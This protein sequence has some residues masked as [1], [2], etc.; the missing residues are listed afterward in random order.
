M[1]RRAFLKALTAGPLFTETLSHAVTEDIPGPGPLGDTL[2]VR[3]DAPDGPL[4]SRAFEIL[5]SRVGKRCPIR[6]VRADTDA[7]LI[8]A[9]SA[10][11]PQEG[12][13][14]ENAEGV[15][16][17][18]GGSPSG[19]IYGVGKFLRTCRYN[20]GFELADWRGTAVPQG[21]FRGLYFASHFHNWYQT[22]PDTEIIE[23]MEDLTLWGVNAL[24]I[25]FP[26]INL[27]DW[28]DPQTS[29]ATAMVRKF[30]RISRD[31][32]VQFGIGAGNALFQ[33]VPASIRATPL[34]DPTHRRGNH[35]YPVCPSNPDGHRYILDTY[36]EVFHRLSD[37]GLD[38][39]VFWPYDE[40][41]CACDKCM[42]WGSNAFFKMAKEITSLGRETFPNL[43]IALSTW[44][45]DTPPE[46]EWQGL[47][48]K[49]ANENGWLDMILADAHEEFPRYPLDS[50]VPGNLP[51]INFP[52]I[53]MWGNAPWGG[54][55]ANPLP[56][57]FQRLWDQVKGVVRGGLPYSEGIY[58][59]MNKAIVVQFYWDSDQTAQAT[60]REYASYE[61]GL[62]DTGEVFSLVD[63]LEAAAS[64]SYK[65]KPVDKAKVV[66]ALGL[67]NSIQ[68]R[69]P[70]WALKSWR[71]EILYLRAILD[72]DRFAG[73]GL[74]SKAAEAA[75]MRLIKIYH[76]E[77]ETEDPYHHR[78]R[79]R[80]KMAKTRGKEL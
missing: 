76:C 75:L 39:L 31:L 19:L 2:K 63:L 78:V 27:R 15:V 48:D 26:L 53:S 35:G 58:E 4:V 62:S 9:V 38:F 8:L 77:L 60:L 44:M 33:G 23:Y 43:K 30:A 18:S 68:S 6:V 32:G 22:A 17:V 54:V 36:R 67:A 5:K 47:T 65:E 55:G 64:D 40:G 79:P 42:P 29:V 66:Q 59:D 71:W 51:L 11:L 49:L 52:E 20:N 80:S 41:G 56:T 61:F 37:I 57:R 24:M 46:G 34:A 16:R 7:Q 14:I 13:S 69:L 50:G 72:N 73:E 28:D 45:F 10:S 21:A 3:V 1:E 70:E 74:E 25:S 12:F